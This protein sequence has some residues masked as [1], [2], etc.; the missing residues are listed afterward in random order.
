MMKKS[1]N[2]NIQFSNLWDGRSFPNCLAGVYTFLEGQGSDT[3]GYCNPDDENKR[4]CFGCGS[5]NNNPSP[6]ATYF[7]L[8]DTMCGRSAVRLRYDGAL[9]KMAEMIGDST[10]WSGKCGTDYTTDFL[11]GFAGYDYQKVIDS[12]A[13][14]DEVA[15]SVDAGKPVIAESAEDGGF[16][17]ITGYDGDNA[18]CSFYS[19]NQADNKR[20]LITKTYL[21][22][23]FKALYV[24]GEKVTP[25]YTL[26]DGL[27]RIKLVMENNVEERIWDKGVEE[28]TKAFISSTDDEFEKMDQ[29]GLKTIQTRFKDTLV[30][31]FNNH[32]F[33]VP[34]FNCKI[35]GLDDPIFREIRDKINMCCSRINK[36][37]HSVF[38]ISG[39]NASRLGSFRAGYGRM[40]LSAI[41]EMDG[42]YAEILEL[43]KLAI[44]V[45]DK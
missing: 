20:E 35:F 29:D 37:D 33:D 26:K 22:N 41:D 15:A 23:D 30:N 14:K 38:G 17:A 16:S 31:R 10:D 40:L 43:V 42:I 28:I 8:F 25:R 21:Y 34:F 1:L 39:I 11:F 24:I 12:A 32:T 19:V 13:F 7:C 27:E 45:L 6:T 18:A 44:A 3:P 5:C 4:V 9:T 2:F 36:Y